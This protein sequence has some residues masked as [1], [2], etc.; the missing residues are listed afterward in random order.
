MNIH[1]HALLAALLGGFSLS[2]CVVDP[3]GVPVAGPGFGGLGY[4]A[5]PPPMV[6]DT[7]VYDTGFSPFFRPAGGVSLTYISTRGSSRSCGRPVYVPPRCAT[8]PV[9]RPICPTPVP[10]ACGPRPFGFGVSTPRIQHGQMLHEVPPS[11]FSGR[12]LRSGGDCS[13]PRL[14]AQPLRLPENHIHRERHESYSQPPIQPSEPSFFS[15]TSVAEPSGLTL[16]SSPIGNSV[17]E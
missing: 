16:V 3:Y 12:G 4:N 15:S 10:P 7:P 6:Y 5:G 1:S 17:Q 8:P 11:P 2:S 14:E 13:L 9:V